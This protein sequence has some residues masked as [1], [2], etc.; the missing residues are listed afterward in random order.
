MDIYKSK[1][2]EYTK[3]NEKLGSNND[4]LLKKNVR[5]NYEKDQAENQKLIAKAGVNALTREIEHL[6][7]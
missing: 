1:L 4:Q 3:K 7:K 5:I 2:T 6:R